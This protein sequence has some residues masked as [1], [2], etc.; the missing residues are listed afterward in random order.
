MMPHTRVESLKKVTQASD[1]KQDAGLVEASGAL[2][3]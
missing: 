2:A 3:L 1:S